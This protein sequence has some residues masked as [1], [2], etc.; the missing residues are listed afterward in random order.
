M[1]KLTS[2][3]VATDLSIRSDRAVRRAAQIAREHG[4][5]LT[6][7]TVLDDAM[8]LEIIDTLH[9][10]ARATLDRFVTSV[11][12]GVNVTIKAEPGDPSAN[13][14]RAC[15][16]EVDLLVMGT[17]RQRPFLDAVRETTMQRIV[18]RIS[19]P[20]LLVTDRVDHAYSTVLS[21]CDF[22]P[23]C[24]GA[25]RMA[26][27]LAPTAAIHPVHA[28]HIPYSGMLSQTKAAADAI[29][30]SFRQEAESAAKAWMRGEDLPSEQMEQLEILAGVPYPILRRKVDTGN[31]D[32]IAVGAHGRVGAARSLLGSLATDLMREPLCDVLIARP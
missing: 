26:H 16:D 1:T 22:S 32:L 30:A 3:L 28:L 7:L 25:M 31:V 17:H 27:A 15:T 21:A 6:V 4:A 19:T 8:P 14:I 20:V 24:S 9:A 11:C 18:R 29:E 10:K 23:A 13:I 5:A 2:I 12:D